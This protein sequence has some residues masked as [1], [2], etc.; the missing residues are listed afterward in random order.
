MTA[1]GV[2]V[3][4]TVHIVFKTHL[5]VG[6]T[7][8]SRRVIDGYCNRFIPGALTLARELRERGG[9]ERFVWTTGAWLIVEYLERADRARR[10]EM[11]RAIVAGDIAWHALPFTVHTELLDASLFRFGLSLAGELDRRFGRKTVAAKMTDVPGHTR[12]MV[13]L[14]AEAGVEFLH[15][16]VNPVSRPPAVPPLFVWRH[17]DGS[18]VMTMLGTGYGAASGVPG[19]T[20]ALHLAHTSDN[21]GPQTSAAVIETFAR[22]RRQ[23]PGATVVAS[24]LDAFARTLR[25]VKSRLPVVTGELGDTWIHGVGTDPVKV[26][27]YRALSRWRQTQPDSPELSRFSRF[28]LLVPEHTWGLDVKTH[29]GD[30]THFV[31]RDF[32]RARRRD[33]VPWKVPPEFAYTQY[34]K[35]HGRPQR[36]SKLERSWAEQRGYISQALR[37]LPAAKSALRPLTPR[38]PSGSGWQMVRDKRAP[39]DFP[40]YAVRL[41][42]ATGALVSLLEKES[43]RDWA[44]PGNPLGWFRYQTFSQADYDRYLRTY[45]IN[46]EQGGHRD[47]AI[48]DF[49]KPGMAAA[50]APSRFWQPRVQRVRRRTDRLLIDL[51]SPA[52]AAKRWGCPAELTL[53]LR[54]PE[55]EWT[56]QWFDKPANRLPEA[57]WFSFVPKLPAHSAWWLDKMGQ[58]ISPDEVVEDGNRR[59]HAIDRGVWWDT[60]SGRLE[61]DSPDIPLVAPGEPGLL[62]FDNECPQIRGGM[63]FNL[64]NNVWGTNFAMWTEGSGRARFALRALPS[65]SKDL[66]P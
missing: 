46:M 59:L 9:D 34:F 5:D 14:L 58:S 12:A 21:A 30:Y 62:Q 50:H 35:N 33:L 56:V 28:L 61:I 24:T 54:F 10:R 41:D 32:E 7:D 4:S 31:R 16:G 52:S 29:L 15:I 66:S 49:S 37:I 18:E 55:V 63:H 43:G 23:F 19:L 38:R 6:F 40:G 2:A 17:C 53:E 20:D 60:P 48:P 3:P 39:L 45:A 44:G 64:F 47:W 26:A 42:P 8:F 22:V 36:Y 65:L 27:R 1:D 13:P 51:A 25:A 11:E 57:M